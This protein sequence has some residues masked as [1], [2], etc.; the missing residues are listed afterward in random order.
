MITTALIS[1]ASY[2]LNGILSLFPVGGGF[3]ASF[4]SA[5]SSLGGYIHILDPLVPI[6]VL[7]S[8]VS[9]IFVVEILLFGFKTFR[10]IISHI[11]Y[12]GGKG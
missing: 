8:C 4:H 9:F 10:W 3:P 6:S 7:L 2:L 1:L 12:I 11:P 5:M